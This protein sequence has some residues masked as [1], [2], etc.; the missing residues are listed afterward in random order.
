MGSTENTSHVREACVEK[1]WPGSS[2]PTVLYYWLET[3]W[4]ERGLSMNTARIQS[5]SSLCCSP[6]SLLA[7]SSFEGFFEQPS[8]GHTISPYIAKTVFST[9][10]WETA[11][12]GLA[13]LE[14]S[15][16]RE[17]NGTNRSTH[18][19]GR[20]WGC[21]WLSSPSFSVHSKFPS[22]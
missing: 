13:S 21:K 17:I 4:V 9:H 18:L 8:H 16:K 11:P 7:A 20:S 12:M 5:C 19:C 14:K 15:W 2:N 3:V 1:E 6:I 10:V 22:P